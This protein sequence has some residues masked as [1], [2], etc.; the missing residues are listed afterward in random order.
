MLISYD[1]K[2]RP[3]EMKDLCAYTKVY[4]L[5]KWDTYQ[6]GNLNSDSASGRT[7]EATRRVRSPRR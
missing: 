6:D 3:G 5:Q 4:V 1:F 2:K 7:S